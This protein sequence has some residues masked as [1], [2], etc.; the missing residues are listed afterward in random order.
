MKDGDK[1]EVEIEGI[2]PRLVNY[3]YDPKMYK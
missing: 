3:A 1:V 2:N